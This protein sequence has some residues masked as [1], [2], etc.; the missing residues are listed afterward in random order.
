MA[1]F[2]KGVYKEKGTG[3]IFKR[4]DIVLTGQKPKE[5]AERVASIHGATVVSY[6]TIS[7]TEEQYRK[8]YGFVIVK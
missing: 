2:I 7:M 6:K 8:K 1:R 4:M 3:K 5:I